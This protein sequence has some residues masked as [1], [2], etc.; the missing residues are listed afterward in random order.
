MTTIETV[1]PADARPWHVLDTS[2]RGLGVD[3]LT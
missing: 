2:I 1:N 3:R